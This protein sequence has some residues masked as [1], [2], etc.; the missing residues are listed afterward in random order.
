MPTPISDTTDQYTRFAASG[1]GF[2]I[3]KLDRRRMAKGAN[4]MTSPIGPVS[5][6]RVTLSGTI[7]PNA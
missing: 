1:D 4:M 7:A 3:T 2:F 5:S 6:V